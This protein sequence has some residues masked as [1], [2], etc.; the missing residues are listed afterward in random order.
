MTDEHENDEHENDEHENGASSLNRKPY[1]SADRGYAS[2]AAGRGIPEAVKDHIGVI[3]RNDKLETAK[4][5]DQFT[6]K[7]KSLKLENTDFENR[8]DDCQRK[9]RKRER[10]IA[11]QDAKLAKLN[12]RLNAPPG[13]E[14]MPSPDPII[15][16]LRDNK[17]HCQEKLSA[18][19]VE[20]RTLKAK[21]KLPL[22]VEFLKNLVELTGIDM[23]KIGFSW[24]Q[25]C[26]ALGYTLSLFGLLF[27][28]YIFYAS[29][30]AKAFSPNE[31]TAEQKNEQSTEQMDAAGQQN[32]QP[33]KQN[34]APLNEYVDSD[35]WH[36][37][38]TAEPKNF[39][40]LLFPM[41]F[42]VF[43]IALHFCISEFLE[44]KLGKYLNR[45]AVLF[46]FLTLCFDIIIAGNI[47][48]NIEDIKRD[49][50]AERQHAENLNLYKRGE[51]D[52]M[53]ENANS[54]SGSADRFW[55]IVSIV[56]LGFVPSLLLTAGIYAT[57]ES[58]KNV[59]PYGEY[60]KQKEHEYQV[61]L[62]TVSAK[63]NALNNEINSLNTQ[64]GERIQANR[65]PLQIEIGRIE[66]EKATQTEEIAAISEAVVNIEEEIDRRQTEIKELEDLLKRP[67][68]NP[69]NTKEME[70]HVKEFVSG[71]CRFVA[72]QKT[73]LT[74]EV[75]GQIRR[76]QQIAQETLDNYKSTI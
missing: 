60:I 35:A 27:Y 55:K 18:A 45:G 74:D 65:H 39:F 43:A 36:D 21:S 24:K 11:D 56:F 69:V 37:A 40:V 1:Y 51:I 7:I 16:D 53:P 10:Q 67:E 14:V 76:I 62:A 17:K 33:N 29:V 73:E 66:T 34:E 8:K 13:A 2:A 20:K 28:L 41:I 52:E 15:K 46:F 61:E 64:I 32:E 49:R 25:F 19:V 3:V 71:W 58:W 9:I 30:A 23:P 57:L 68:V 63:I 12:A 31:Q 72:W 44:S 4:R 5:H 50:E 6:E 54:T 70:E 47:S 59:R 38:W 48:G 75:A 42:I 22:T 26:V